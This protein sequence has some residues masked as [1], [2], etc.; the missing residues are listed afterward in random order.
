MR[1]HC[2]VERHECRFVALTGGPS[3]GK[4]AVLEVVRRNFCEHVGVLPEAASVVFGGGFPRLT[5]DV[6]RR[7]G[8]RAIYA[9]QR[10]LERW[11]KESGRFAVAL[12]DRG[13]L[14]GLAYWPGPKAE[15]FR[16]L[17][18]SE[19]AELRRY[20]TIVHLHT[21]AAEAYD[22]SNPLRVEAP[23]DALDLDA[24]VLEVWRGH[25][26]RIEIDS[27][28]TFLGKLQRA[29]AAVRD[30][31]PRCCREHFVPELDAEEKG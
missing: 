16:E 7:A 4:T 5:D 14:D 17:G 2:D 8:Q 3:A 1:C 31:V 29:I 28:D 25:P 18:T 22:R 26:R 30:V 6:T 21:P 12:C 15:F 24:R 19:E 11:A 27:A 23:A 9:V 13:T 20:E 10:E